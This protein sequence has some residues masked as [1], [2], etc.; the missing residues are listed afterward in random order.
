MCRVSPQSS[1][2]IGIAVAVVVV[3]FVLIGI[4]VALMLR[5]K[6]AHVGRQRLFAIA[7]SH[8]TSGARA[9]RQS[10]SAGRRWRSAT[11]FVRRVVT[12]TSAASRW[13]RFPQRARRQQRDLCRQRRA[14]CASVGRSVVG[15]LLCAFARQNYQTSACSGALCKR[16]R[17]CCVVD[18]ADSAPTRSATIGTGLTSSSASTSVVV[19]AR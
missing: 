17:V 1:I 19:G 18:R 8:L 2:I 11:A 9:E 12:Q 7:S 4:I 14:R 16:M 13:S 6:N 10:R 5:K 3:V 15:S